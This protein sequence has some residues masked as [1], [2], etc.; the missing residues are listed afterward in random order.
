MAIFDKL[1]GRRDDDDEFMSLPT[2]A[3]G[4][5]SGAFGP[6]GETA[7]LAS[8]PQ[9]PTP[10]AP[11]AAQ[12]SASQIQMSNR[13]EILARQITS[14]VGEIDVLKREIAELKNK[15]AAPQQPQQQQQSSGYGQQDTN[16]FGSFQTQQPPQQ[17]QQ[18]QQQPPQEQNWQSP[19]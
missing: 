9:L 17:T 19:W 6:A 7:G 12:S 13:L 16:A 14:L 11:A 15:S 5:P 2:G 4:G 8:A 1:R 10:V 18:P 3:I